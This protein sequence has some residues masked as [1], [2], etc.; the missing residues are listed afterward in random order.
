MLITN[1]TI[2][3]CNVPNEILSG[4]S[5]LIRD[6]RIADLLPDSE[7]LSKYPSEETY[8]V[9]N[10]LVMPGAIC[11]HTHFYGAFSRG[12]AI[13][14][15]APATFHQILNKLW[16]PLDQSLTAE[17]V[18][19]SA[20][21]CEADAIRHGMTTLFDHH[22][23]PNFI[24]GSLDVIADTV[25]K[26]GLRAALC[27][28]VTDRGGD[29]E[30]DAGIRENLRF[31]DKTNLNPDGQL[32]GFFGLHA[33]LTLSRTTLEK[34][35]AVR[36]P[37]FGFHTHLSESRD[38]QAHTQKEFGQDP[39]PLFE[40]F[41]LLDGNSIL[42]HCVH[43]ADKDVDILKEK[44][45]WVTHQPRSNMNNAV[46]TARVEK[47]LTAGIPVALGNDGFSNSH[48]DEMKAAYLVHKSAL[49][50]PRAMGGYTVMDLAYTNTA[51]MA[52]HFFNMP[53]GTIKVGAAADLVVVDYCPPTELNKF[54]FPWHLLF[55]FRDQMIESTIA[56]GKFLMK[57][58]KLLTL[59]EKAIAEKCSELSHKVWERYAK[60]F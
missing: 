15:D 45:V 29:S 2:V 12:M 24:D 48:W 59:D 49:G 32:V 55:G 27:Y 39:V 57:E 10:K 31:V 13:P 51:K 33:P 37:H 56:N 8:N 14:G 17:D 52:S 20:L 21:L 6:G 5:L 35:A 34:C 40:Q 41:G 23:S 44:G 16:W 42:A 18:E 4:H 3:T 43:V 19:Y 46:G 28:E 22:A 9:G 54:N 30:R 25:K 38:D 53:L 7:A 50:D 58:R 60:K 11:A 47:M 36:A 1:A 26:A